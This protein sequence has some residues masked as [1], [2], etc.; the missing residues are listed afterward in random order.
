MWSPFV[1][2]WQASFSLDNDKILASVSLVCFISV[3]VM[4]VKRLL[5]AFSHCELV[6]QKGGSARYLAEKGFFNVNA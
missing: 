1:P 2:S 4:M 5:Q 6:I 3:G